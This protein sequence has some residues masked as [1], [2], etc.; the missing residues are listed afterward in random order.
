MFP[1]SLSGGTCLRSAA[2]SLFKKGVDPIDRICADIH[3]E[4]IVV[5]NVIRTVLR[6]PAFKSVYF[7][8]E[9]DNQISVFAFR[10]GEARQGRR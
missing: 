7:L 10:A 9:I 3:I 8:I 4:E 1:D 5:E 6:E 2:S